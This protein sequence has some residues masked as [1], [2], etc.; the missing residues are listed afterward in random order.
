MRWSLA[1]VAVAALAGAAVAPAADSIS[2]LAERLAGLRGEVES[3]SAQITAEQNDLQNELK[4][5]AR[6]KAE[7]EAEIA[8]EKLRLQKTR[9]MVSER[10]AQ[11]EKAEAADKELAPI[12]DASIEKVR[13]YIATTLPFRRAER[14]AELDKIQD[15]TKQGLLT[16]E[17]GLARLWSY[18]E[19][20]FRL[21][22][23]S[24]VYRQTVTLDGTDNLADVVRIGMVGLFYRTS[25]GEYGY[26]TRDGGQ[27][28]WR[29]QS[30]SGKQN[31]AMVENLFESFRK[32]IRVGYFEIPAGLSLGG[33]L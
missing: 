18:L 10:R 4:S 11:I 19:D 15:Q 24:G 32:Q 22:G 25:D 30:L 27:G 3:L 26:A 7:L 31:V 21:T 17:R 14:L 20:E 1:V 23:E 29:F 16:P 6:Q 9:A 12:L 2:Q 5:L 8:R 33:A 13:T 28:T